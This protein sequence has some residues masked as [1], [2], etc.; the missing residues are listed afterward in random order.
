M[1]VTMVITLME[2]DDF[3][4]VGGDIVDDGDGC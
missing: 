1:V 2:V 3:D 4:S